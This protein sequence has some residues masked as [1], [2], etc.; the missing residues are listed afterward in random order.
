ML[1][2]TKKK[3][4]NERRR[5]CIFIMWPMPTQNQRKFKIRTTKKFYFI[6]ENA[7]LKHTAMKTAIIVQQMK[8][9][10]A[11]NTNWQKSSMTLTNFYATLGTKRT[12]ALACN[13]K[14]QKK[15]I[16]ARVKFW[17]MCKCSFAMNRTTHT[18]HAR[19]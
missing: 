19:I 14:K 4:D 18:G 8:N 3:R 1:H 17:F 6:F 11:F 9:K 5:T 2:A 12:G 16:D 10:N 13:S 15:R 7:Q